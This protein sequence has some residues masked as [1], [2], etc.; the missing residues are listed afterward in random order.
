MLKQ[1]SI[2]LLV[3]ILAS[4][5]TVNVTQYFDDSSC[6]TEVAFAIQAINDKQLENAVKE[7]MK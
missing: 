3:A 1:A 5:L 7:S 2:L 6:T 4:S